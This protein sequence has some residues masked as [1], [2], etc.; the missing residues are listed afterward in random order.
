MSTAFAHAQ[1]ATSFELEKQIREAANSSIVDALMSLSDGMLAVLNQHRQLIAVNTTLLKNIGA[2]D[3][4]SIL[5]MRFGEAAGCINSRKSPS[6]CGT[7]KVCSSCGAAIAMLASITSQKTTEKDCA[8]SICSNGEMKNMVFRVKAA[9]FN[10]SEEPMLLFFIQDHTRQARLASIEKTFFHDLN[11][12]LTS[13]LGLSELA[14]ESKFAQ[15]L[16]LIQSINNAAHKLAKEVE[17]QRFLLTEKMENLSQ[18]FQA[19]SL[20]DLFNDAINAILAHPSSKDIIIAIPESY[21]PINIYTE[22]VI[23]VRVLQNMLIN[24][25]EA[26]K[27]NQQV[28]FWF[29][30]DQCNHII[31]KVW[32]EKVI[33]ENIQPRIFQRNIVSAK[34]EGHGVGT[35]SMKLLSEDAL[36]AKIIFESTPDS[37][38]TFSLS[39]PVEVI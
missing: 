29:E 18:R 4:Q 12:S 24:A 10:L 31:F 13:I 26:S 32:N 21:P 28:R 15:N 2:E 5:G 23:L 33:P 1:R 11:N 22:P 7:S 14:I 36:C 27:A 3:A 9:P 6:G 38:T 39:V 25:C 19:V 34:G 37:G 16:E 35:Y 8:I 20:E 17:I 30:I